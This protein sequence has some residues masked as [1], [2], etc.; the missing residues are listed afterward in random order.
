MSLADK[1]NMWANDAE[2]QS[3]E[4]MIHG[5]DEEWLEGVEDDI[6][7]DPPS[8][9][10]L[11]LYSRAILDSGAY[12]LLLEDLQRESLL[13]SDASRVRT[14]DT[15]RHQ[16]MSG[17]SLTRISKN[18]DPCIHE[19]EFVVPLGGI[20]RR[21]W[22]EATRRAANPE[23]YDPATAIV[24]VSSSNNY[25]QAVTLGEYI[26]Q[27]WG[28][29]GSRLLDLVKSI[30]AQDFETVNSRS[31]TCDGL[32]SVR[33]SVSS[34]DILSVRAKGLSYSVSEYGAELC[35][36]L[37]ALQTCDAVEPTCFRPSVINAGS[38]EPWEISTLID[39]TF[40]SASNISG[41]SALRMFGWFSRIVEP[42]IVQ[43]FPTVYRPPEYA[44]VEGSLTVLLSLVHQDGFHWVEH[45]MHF[46]GLRGTLQLV[47][48]KG[49]LCFW[50]GATA[51]KA[52]HCPKDLKR[53]SLMDIKKS[54]HIL[55]DC[56]QRSLVPPE[57]DIMPPARDTSRV[58]EFSEASYGSPYEAVSTISMDLFG[59]SESTT[60]CPDTSVDSDMMSI[61]DTPEAAANIPDEL[62]PVLDAV[63][64]QLHQEYKD[65]TS[66]SEPDRTSSLLRPMDA[67]QHH[68]RPLVEHTQHQ[69]QSESTTDTS[70]THAD[71]QSTLGSEPSTSRAKRSRTSEDSHD[72]DGQDKMG[73]PPKKPRRSHTVTLPARKVLACPFWKLD[74]ARY[75]QCL[76]LECFWEVNRVK[77][78]LTRKHVEPKI[79]CD[80]CKLTFRDEPTKITHLRQDRATCVYKPWT[81]RLITRSQQGELHKKS[82]ADTERDKWF[83]VWDI[84]FPGVPRPPSPFIDESVSE[85]FR[86]FREYAGRRGRTILLE[87]LRMA[88][89]AHQQDGLFSEDSMESYRLEAVERALDFI[90]DDFLADRASSERSAIGRGSSGPGSP[91]RAT[92]ASSLADSGMGMSLN[93]TVEIGD[94]S[95]GSG[96]G[97][98][99][100]FSFVFGNYE[101]PLDFP[102]FAENAG[103]LDEVIRGFDAEDTR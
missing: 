102:L 27:T 1:M 28:S 99:E 35:W 24:L 20:K 91:G 17:F 16:I 26:D 81:E 94:I 55:G 95:D 87:R 40:G 85:D 63:A 49:G 29:G 59:S 92:P 67:S 33:H 22:K 71:T 96:H 54:R 68:S 72:K 30:P 50:H 15:V 36:V 86:H 25:S 83:D 57:L 82:K 51:E 31:Y 34:P 66:G 3:Q 70:N 64:R 41:L 97:V 77:Q 11:A 90:M 58:G 2:G 60:M 4:P 47:K 44:G 12:K 8:H 7:D 100:E 78:H 46:S 53:H 9:S 69:D 62:S 38:G 23:F 75:R 19:V 52:C 103:A 21:L 45:S 61:P 101:T 5:P 6:E 10:D 43:G 79:Y 73:P 13:H 80:M 65:V 74:P 39:T 89:F 14:M 48:Q 56:L 88:G 37:S 18:Q 76:K 98:F 42:V 93:P 84:L 32:V